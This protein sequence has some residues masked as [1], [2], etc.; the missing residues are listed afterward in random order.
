MKITKLA[1]LSAIFLC[2]FQLQ[3]QVHTYKTQ[4]YTVH[5]SQAKAEE[6]V[7]Y[8]VANPPGKSSAQ[9][10]DD[11][12]RII[13]KLKAAP[14]AARSENGRKAAQVELDVEH[15]QFRDLL[16]NIERRASTGRKPAAPTVILNEYKNTFNGFALITTKGMAEELKKQKM[17]YSVT[18]SR[19][20][21]AYDLNSNQTI[22]VPAA[23]N[24]Y[25][26]SGQ[27]ITI[28][29]I[30]TGIDYNHQDLGGGFGSSFK[31]VGGYDF[32]NNDNDPIDDNG[33]GTHVAGIAAANGSNLKGV[34]PNAK[35]VAYKVLGAEGYG[36]D[37]MILAAIERTTDPDQNPSTND[38]LDVVNMSLGR[39][40]DPA[41]PYSEAVNNAVA[42]GVNFVVAAGNSWDYFTIG[43]PA[44]AEKAITVGAVDNNK[45][46]AYFSSKGPVER[47][48][49]LKPD[50]AAPGVQIHSSFLNNNYLSLDGTSMATP[51]VAGAVALLLEKNSS[52]TPPQVKAAL[53]N[54]ATPLY[55]ANIWEQG[56][57]VVDVLKAINPATTI[58]P[59]SISLGKP[60]TGAQLW[61][62]IV[63]IRI[64]NHTNSLK[65]YSLT[66]SGDLNNGAIAVAFSEQSFALGAGAEKSVD[67]T[68][69]IDAASLPRRNLPECYTG[70]IQVNDGS[71]VVSSVV[72][73]VN[74]QVTSLTFTNELP[75]NFF[76]M[77][78]DGGY[79]YK[80]IAVSSTKHEVYLPNGTF[81]ILT[82]YMDN[83]IVITESISSEQDISLTID[84]SLAKNVIT[85]D[86]VDKDGN[87]MLGGQYYPNGSALFYSTRKNFLTLFPGFVSS[88]MISDNTRYRFD[89]S[90]NAPGS[91]DGEFYEVF[92]STGYGFNQSMAVKNIPSDYSEV[93]L[94]TPGVTAGSYQNVTYYTK[95]GLPWFYMNSW[96]SYP[97]PLRS[98]ITF[99]QS[100]SDRHV[101]ILGSME[102][103]PFGESSG[104][105]WTAPYMKPV[106]E[107][108]IF[109]NHFNNE[110]DSTGSTSLELELGKSVISFNAFVYN[111]GTSM[112]L[113]DFPAK[114]LFRRSRGERE[115]GNVAYKITANGAITTGTIHNASSPFTST[116]LYTQLPLTNITL[117][118]EYRDY[119]VGGNFGK[120]TAVLKF[121][122]AAADPNPPTLSHF[123]LKANG[124]VT[125]E[126]KQG[127]I[128]M[129]SFK[130]IDHCSDDFYCPS[131]GIQS[132][133]LKYRKT[134]TET[135]I[136]VPLSGNT[137]YEAELPGDLDEGYYSFLISATDLFNNSLTTLIDP[138][139][140][141]GESDSE[142][143]YNTIQ[144]LQPK[145][146][147]SNTGINPVFRWSSIEG[148]TYTLQI[149]NTADF[150]NPQIFETNQSTYEIPVSLIA[151]QTYFWRVQ[152]HVNESDTPWSSYFQFVSSTLMPPTL[153]SP[154]NN[155]IG[156][157]PTAEMS[158]SAVPNAWYYIIEL[159]TVQD[160]S[161]PVLM[162][163]SNGNS[164]LIQN[165]LHHETY[166][167]KVTAVIPAY[168][169]IYQ[170]TS[171]TWKF[172]T[173]D[174][175]V[176]IPEEARNDKWHATP[177][178]F[179][180]NTMIIG[181]S[182]DYDKGVIVIHDQL[183]REVY[184]SAIALNTGINNLT[185]DGRSINGVNLPDGLYT[186]LI[187][188]QRQAQ[189][190]RLSINR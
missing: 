113:Y 180:T 130:M 138:A 1:F 174:G 101:N 182:R 165:L 80:S 161:Q 160:F 171:E 12:T 79:Y 24:Q 50:V 37:D 181:F 16:N 135:W 60:E 121:D 188:T 28:G 167:W 136:E 187:K 162:A 148:A 25:G 133:T 57:G 58:Y 159:S 147:A 53:M 154:L 45:F 49:A 31:V 77:S 190:I 9:L 189:T 170:V 5:E 173:G 81:D 34:A 102:L 63:N 108:I 6:K 134:D 111:Y 92:G 70:S 10:A 15:Q 21:K 156:V 20:V 146:Y 36:Y 94:I 14:L 89:M 118:L 83:S 69:T 164:Y 65:T 100:P 84:K 72:S 123:M 124:D 8:F 132:V 139:F 157:S 86:P 168:F 127:D 47:S 106:D 177:N 126:L 3:A 116:E 73:L 104:Y 169:E 64:K 176:G 29:I 68:F 61:E 78:A 122:N 144:L 42:S 110:I 163:T 87:S 54:T 109:Y 179:K 120:T 141:I 98:P 85:F 183:G 119:Q 175:A 19:R 71:S 44:I 185:W 82:Y 7:N 115:D 137:I 56:A 41:E 112:F 151:D 33:H 76:V 18:Q 149:S 13:V 62:K 17:V 93:K 153:I 155:S 27:G 23:Q 114:G 46:T 11:T 186:A 51:H 129:V 97:W 172:S 142:V 26:V 55:A 43:T 48:F 178:P 125:N 96:N 91:L 52:W 152:G 35:L 107:K 75:W 140:I 39:Y 150:A 38:A 4:R 59:G 40:A 74:P 103:A 158:W 99:Y 22:N 90:F 128:P 166:Y 131:Y 143:P 184:R 30:D 105:K 2:A 117:E 95:N 66:K 32:F 145:N 88:I 67:I